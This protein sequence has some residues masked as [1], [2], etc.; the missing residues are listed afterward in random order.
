MRKKTSNLLHN[1][2]QHTNALTIRK[3]TKGIKENTSFVST[4]AIL[5]GLLFFSCEETTIKDVVNG[6]VYSI[7]GFAQKGP[8]VVGTDVTVAEL[9]NKLVPTG[10]IFFATVLDD[11]GR[12]E[13]PG[14]VL[15]SPYV[16]IK[17]TGLYYSELRGIIY[18]D[19]LTL[20]SLADVSKSETINVNI[21]THLESKRVEYLVQQENLSFDEAKAKAF[22]EFLT[23]FNW[24]NHAVVTSE[25]LDISMND[26]G[27]AILLATACLFEG[28][29]DEF[30]DRLAKITDFRTDFADG[31]I[32]SV[33]T[34]N[35]L[36][37]A[38]S[39]LNE[40][41]T[42]FNLKYHYGE[43]EFPDFMP[44]INEFKEN[45]SYTDYTTFTDIIPSTVDNKINLLKLTG[46]NIIL[47]PNNNYYILINPSGPLP[48]AKLEFYVNYDNTNKFSLQ[49]DPDIIFYPTNNYYA[50]TNNNKHWL[51]KSIGVN[52]IS[53]GGYWAGSCSYYLY[54]DGLYISGNTVRFKY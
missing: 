36:R 10:R 1:F 46:E 15:E 14:V 5:I 29:Q 27:G 20:F 17:I 45:S 9:N 31:K 22:K 7:E 50:Y 13:L 42:L 32:N 3:D 35:L 2:I 19:E 44:L 23:V 12:F 40:N 51:Q 33:R 52:F 43:K 11:N 38:A 48:N 21:I 16:Q 53:S 6:H 41:Q 30:V 54:V 34:Q 18:E 24:E 47:N 28:M 49:P 4:L 37:T 8:F 39:L 26:E 25:L